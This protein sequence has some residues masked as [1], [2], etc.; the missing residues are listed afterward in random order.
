MLQRRLDPYI[1]VNGDNTTGCFD[2]HTASRPDEEYFVASTDAIHQLMCAMSKF[3]GR[4]P[5]C[6]F[7]FDLQ[8]FEYLRRGHAVRINLS[9]VAGHSMRWFSSSITSGKFTANLRYGTIVSV[10][11]DNFDIQDYCQNCTCPFSRM[12]HGFI[13]TGES[14]PANSHGFTV[15]LTV[16]GIN[17]RSHDLASKSHGESENLEI[18]KQFG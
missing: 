1:L 11:K 4:C 3:S 15:R 2:I 7:N 6:G 18:A 9:C 13:S 16:W 8:A 14:R 5:L 10:S 12:I 17:S